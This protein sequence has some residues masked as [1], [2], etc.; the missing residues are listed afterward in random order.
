MYEKYLSTIES[1]MLLVGGS[2]PTHLKHSDIVK[3]DHFPGLVVGG[4]N[5][6]IFETTT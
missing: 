3:M 5:K 6:K 2:F 1:S 4:E